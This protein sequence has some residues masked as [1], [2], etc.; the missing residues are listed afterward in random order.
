MTDHGMDIRKGIVDN[1]LDGVI[2]V[3]L[4]GAIALFNPAAGR[5]LGI[6]PDAATGKTFAQLFIPRK[7][8]EAFTDLVLD[9]VE[10]RG[11]GGRQIVVLHTGGEERSLSVA[12][13]YLGSS[14]DDTTDPT[15]VIVAFSDTSE[16]RELRMAK[17]VEAQH[18]ELKMAYRQIEEDNKLLKKS[19]AA[20]V[21]A[22]VLVIGVF[23]GAG[24]YTW[25][26]RDPF[27]GSLASTDI[28]EGLPL[29]PEAAIGEGL[30]TLTIEPE[31]L[32]TTISLVGELAPWRTVNVVS[33][34]ASR[35]GAVHFQYGQ[36]V[37]EGELLIEL[38]T[39]EANREYREARVAY[40]EALE[41]FEA[42]KNW[43]TGPEMSDARRSFARASLELKSQRNRLNRAAFL[44]EQGL[45]AATE[46][47][48]AEQQYQN[49]QLDFEAAE[50]DFAAVR[51]RGGKD[52][53]D[54]AELELGNAREKMLQFEA[55][56]QQSAIHAPLSGIIL[57][58]ARSDSRGLAAGQSVDKGEVLLKIGDFARM[59][60]VAKV[61]ELD[62]VRIE[63]G[64]AVSVSGNAFPDLSLEGTVSHV[65]SQAEARTRGA[66]EF[67]VSVTIDPL[68]ASQQEQLRAGMSSNLTIVV[69]RNDAALLVP[70][71]AVE[72]QGASNQLLVVDPESGEVQ[73]REIEIGNTTLDAVEVV[74]GL[75]PGDQIVVAAD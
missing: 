27:S 13:S 4:S 53:R 50:Q 33:P 70:I 38:D 63:N 23:L 10:N 72:Q 31:T 45:V 24:A 17:A 2:V 74:A 69:Y 36:Q 39:S 11:K 30:R 58:P 65:S 42:L 14:R 52:A 64:Q 59:S 7:G 75:R 9:A 61:D 66:P 56:L 41:K 32:R 35:I 46:H 22:T 73:E 34:V 16:L 28:D 6:F 54:K 55:N 71:D 67:E 44:L 3:E 12:I 1:L 26:S 29:A 49:Q 21:L 60:A 47:E 48:D 8:F 68:L 43:E 57:V 25:Q 51:A 5:I 37:T 19:Q 40:I 18:G 20:R 15:A 62:V